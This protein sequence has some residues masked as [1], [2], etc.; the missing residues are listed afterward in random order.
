MR[1]SLVA[2]ALVLCAVLGS[3]RT[4]LAQC[5]G[6]LNGDL[7]VT[8]DEILRA[9]NSA[10]NGCDVAEPTPTPT[11]CDLVYTCTCANGCGACGVGGD[12]GDVRENVSCENANDICLYKD[13]PCNNPQLTGCDGS[14]VFVHG[15][16]CVP[17]P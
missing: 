17:N 11:P 14:R 8:V 2:M 4:T 9:V 3:A 1:T 13:G 7:E 10:L 12:P 5:D 15:W 6:D 16:T